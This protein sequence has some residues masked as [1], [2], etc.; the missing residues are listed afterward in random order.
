MKSS[1]LRLFPVFLLMTGMVSGSE[2]KATKG[3]EKRLSVFQ[4]VSGT[5]L[6]QD[7]H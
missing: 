2:K 1:L 4:N 7:V 6:T 5:I 3:G